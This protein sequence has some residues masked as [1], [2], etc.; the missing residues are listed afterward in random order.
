MLYA[1]ESLSMV[2]IYWVFHSDLEYSY[3]T[4]LET[5]GLKSEQEDQGWKKETDML[6][7]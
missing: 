1:F 3:A 4:E 5:S 6:L 2:K 7:G